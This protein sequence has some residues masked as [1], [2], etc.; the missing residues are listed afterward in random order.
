MS[1]TSVHKSY[2]HTSTDL[3][4]WHQY[5]GDATNDCAAFCIAM[6]GNAFLNNPQFDGHTVAREMEK[7][8]WVRSPVPHIAIRKLRN[9]ATL[10]WGISGYLQ[11][12][13]IPAR[14]RWRGSTEDLLRNIQENRFTI[15]IL[16]EPFRLEGLRFRGWAHA[17]VLYGFEPI[18]P[19]PERG[20]YFVDPGYPREWSRPQQP[21]GVF[22]QDEAEFRQQ[23]G[24]MLRP[25]VEVGT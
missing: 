15:V 8:V 24:N 3:F 13:H 6:V 4:Q 9:W 12:K 1:S 22:R 14:L 5:Q 16:G 20:F 19:Q 21:R 23:W 25:Y 17:K 7:P 18:G 11:A 10:P 2:Y